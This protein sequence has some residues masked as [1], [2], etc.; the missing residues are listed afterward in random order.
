MLL[1]LL[2]QKVELYLLNSFNIKSRLYGMGGKYS[3][4]LPPNNIFEKDFECP[5]C[6]DIMI[7]PSR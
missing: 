3:P 4:T 2:L 6:Y 1:Y 5:V 7:P